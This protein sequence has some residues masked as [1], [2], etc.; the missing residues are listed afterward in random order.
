MIKIIQ[1]FSDRYLSKDKLPWS[2][3]KITLCIGLFLWLKNY[4]EGDM[5]FWETF[6]DTLL[7]WD[8]LYIMG[9]EAIVKFI[10]LVFIF[11]DIWVTL[12]TIT[13]FWGIYYSYKLANPKKKFTDYIKDNAGKVM[14]LSKFKNSFRKF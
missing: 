12:N 8:T 14:N 9:V 13:P 11:S 2:L 6:L 1:S 7:R 4:S 3:T 10:A 5:S